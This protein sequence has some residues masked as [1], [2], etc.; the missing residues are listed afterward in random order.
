M[1]SPQVSRRTLA[2]GAAWTLP[3]VAVAV[4]APAYAA[5][6]ILAPTVDAGASCKCP[7]S[8]GNNFNFKAVLA[9][10][11]PGNDDWKIHA[12]SWT[13]DGVNVAALPADTTLADGEGNVILVV[14]RSNSAAKH[15]SRSSTRRRTSPRWRRSAVPSARWSSTF[16]PNCASP[17][18]CP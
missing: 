3:M 10:T 7:G 18:N 1:S 8:G 15:T 2:R 16:S 14:N 4:A 12:T 11:T 17:I 9:F 6:Q 5:S 13:F